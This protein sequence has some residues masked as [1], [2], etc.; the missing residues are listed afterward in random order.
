MGLLITASLHYLSPT[1]DSRITA[2]SKDVMARVGRQLVEEK[3]ATILAEASVSGNLQKKEFK[4]K[5]ILSVIGKL[6][7]TAFDDLR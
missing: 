3:R 4:G 1:E 6:Y 5:D 7:S 2:E